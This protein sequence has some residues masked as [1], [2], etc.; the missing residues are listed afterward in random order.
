MS[1]SQLVGILTLVGTLLVAG[2][3][4]GRAEQKLNDALRRIEKLETVQEY[5]HGRITVPAPDQ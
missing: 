3:V 1:T 2:I 4:L 5:I